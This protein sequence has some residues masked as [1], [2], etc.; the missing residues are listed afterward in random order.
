MNKWTL[1]QSARILME[2]LQFTRSADE[3]YYSYSK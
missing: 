2:R 1:K 3:V